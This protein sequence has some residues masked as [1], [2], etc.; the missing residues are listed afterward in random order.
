MRG[1]AR[2][3]DAGGVDSVGRRIQRPVQAGPRA[4][5][6]RRGAGRPGRGRPW[7]PGPGVHGAAD[8]EAAADTACAA[9]QP[10]DVAPVP[11]LAGLD[12]AGVD[13]F[14]VDCAVTL[15]RLYVFFVVEV[16]THH[17]HVLGVTAYPD[18]AWTVQQARNLLMELG[19]GPAGSSCWSGPGR[20]VHRGV[21]RGACCCRDRGGEDP[22]AEPESERYAE[23]WVRTVRA[24]VTDRM[25]IA[26]PRHLRAVLDEYVAHYNQHRP[27]WARNLRPPGT[28]D[29]FTASVT[30]L[31]AVRMGRHGVPGGLIQEYERGGMKVIAWFGNLRLRCRRRTSGTLHVPEGVSLV[32]ATSDGQRAEGPSL[33]R[34][35][36][37]AATGSP[38]AD[39]R[40]GGPA[41][42]RQSIRRSHTPAILPAPTAGRKA[43]RPAGVAASR[44]GGGTLSRAGLA[45]PGG[46]PRRPRAWR[47]CTGG[48]AG[49][50]P[51]S[52]CTAL[53]CAGRR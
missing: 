46:R 45:A 38:S 52:A 51:R 49:A 31:A 8:P 39:R 24:E 11:A 21:R 37:P 16:G 13:F 10:H 27:H 18:G 36:R 19:S 5:A 34:L 4:P 25:L 6:R 42:I 12:H 47:P 43:R 7:L 2:N 3:S 30:D 15:R 17:V 22:A 29:I 33:V 1:N 53:H 50:L 35:T 32:T 14:H 26:G 28:D 44:A 41:D 9:A 40:S 23:R 48:S 20:A